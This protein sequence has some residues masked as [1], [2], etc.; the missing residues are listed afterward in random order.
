MGFFSLQVRGILLQSFMKFEDLEQKVY[1]YFF[2]LCASMTSYSS[3]TMKARKGAVL[4]CVCM[5]IYDSEGTITANFSLLDSRGS[6]DISTEPD[7]QTGIILFNPLPDLSF[8]Y[9]SI[10]VAS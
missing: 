5:H 10:F 7:F 6:L 2:F 1:L 9:L 8:L 4:D 3:F